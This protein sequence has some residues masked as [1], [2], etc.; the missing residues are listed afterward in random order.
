[1]IDH[2]IKSNKVFMIEK[3]DQ[4]GITTKE[5][6]VLKQI[7]DKTTFWVRNIQ[8][9]V[10]DMTP[11]NFSV[12]AEILNGLMSF[13]GKALFREEFDHFMD[14]MQKRVK[15]YL[16][17]HEYSLDNIIKTLQRDAVSGT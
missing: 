1:M 15:L 11:I 8:N 3:P 9:N 10:V 14:F 16:V 17:N 7:Y 2:M 5:S 6:D 13:R 4:A 12:A